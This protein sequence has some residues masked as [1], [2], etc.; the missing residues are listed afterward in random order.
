MSGIGDTIA[1]KSDQLNAI[2][3]IGGEEVY[4]ITGVTV[5]P[6]SDQPVSIFTDRTQPYKPSKGMR[7]V[8]IACWGKKDQEYIGRSIRLYR[9]PSVTWA[10][11]EDGGIRVNAL[12]H[13]DSVVKIPIPLNKRKREIITVNPMPFYSEKDF[14]EKLPM[15]LKTIADGKMNIDQAIE[16]LQQTSPLTDTQKLQITQP[17]ELN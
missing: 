11:Q 6:S 3:L 8:L 1:A 5:N 2:D 10:G 13:M 16:R 15:I 14:S 17:K 12:S 7:R 4:T 9:E